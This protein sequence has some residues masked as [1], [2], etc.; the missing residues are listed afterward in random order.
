M[1]RPTEDLCETLRVRV[2]SEQMKMLRDEASMT[3]LSL[4]EV[5]RG[6][7]TGWNVGLFD[8]IAEEIDT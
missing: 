7:L 4:S 5:I 3:G 6:K 1:S 2:N 8:E